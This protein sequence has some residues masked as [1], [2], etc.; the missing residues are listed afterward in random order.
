MT[1]ITWTATGETFEITNLETWAA[2]LGLDY[3]AL[4]GGEVVNDFVCV[5]T[6]HVNDGYLI[7][8]K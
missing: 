8:L 4:L 2:A 3:D 1:Q 5:R 7:K 6:G